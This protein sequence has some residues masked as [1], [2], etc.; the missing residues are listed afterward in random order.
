[1]DYD[2]LTN[3]FETYNK[4]EDGREDEF[5]KT[6]FPVAFKVS[7]PIWLGRVTPVIHYTM[8]GLK[9]FNIEQR[10]RPSALSPQSSF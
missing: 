3:T 8:G 5:G 7:E 4:N 2:T 6:R 9:V 10:E 1:M